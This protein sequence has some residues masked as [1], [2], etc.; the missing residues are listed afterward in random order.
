V[1]SKVFIHFQLAGVR[2]SPF[3]GEKPGSTTGVIQRLAFGARH[4]YEDPV[5][6]SFICGALKL[7]GTITWH[8]AQTWVMLSR[9]ASASRWARLDF[10]RSK[11]SLRSI[12]DLRTAPTGQRLAHTRHLWPFLCRH[13]SFLLTRGLSPNLAS[14]TRLP[15]RPAH[16][17]GVISCA[18]TRG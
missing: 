10:R 6:T 8:L 3:P 16:P 7:H 18:F 14:V 13:S 15:S 12:P 5:T 1:Q 4:L 17:E 9:P 2:P 11:H